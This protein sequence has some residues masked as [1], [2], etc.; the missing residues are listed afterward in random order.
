[1]YKRIITLP[2]PGTETFFLW[3]PRQTGKS[4]LLKERYADAIWIDLLKAD[5]YRRYIQ[6]PELLREELDA[7]SD[8]PFVVID[9]IQKVPHFLDEVH[10]LHENRNVRFALC[11]SS[12]RKVKR[13][14]ANL[15]GGRALRFEL[16]G[17]VLPELQN[18]WNLNELLNNGYL[19]KWVKSPNRRAMAGY[20]GDYLKEEI[21]AEGLVQN[22][23]T[24]SEFLSMA[25]LCD[26]E[27]VNF[28]NI[29]RDCGVST[30]T[31][32]NYFNIL[33]DT[34]LI[35]FLPS[36]LKRPKRRPHKSPKLYFFD[37]GVVNF[38]ARR[39]TLEAR[40]SLYGKAFENYC[41]HELATYND[42]MERFEQL[43][44]WRLSTGAEVDFIVGDMRVAIEAKAAAGIHDGHLKG[45]RELKK[46]YPECERRIVVSLEPVARKTRDGIEI[47]P[48]R[49]FLEKLWDGAFW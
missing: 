42:T 10:W 32:K 8:C 30:V 35:R 41:Y 39:G 23:P 28:S 27:S 19:P 26:T 24:F 29:A 36:Y 4:T 5:T 15:L 46:E 43:Y 31:A 37:V 16:G 14:H 25:A 47:Y 1:M 22:L 12:A 40:S 48:V 7:R 18:D 33:E 2:D 3:G 11:G 34:L 21:A 17:L 44:Y 45:L 38:L 20:V 6:R 13:G 49:E 9:E